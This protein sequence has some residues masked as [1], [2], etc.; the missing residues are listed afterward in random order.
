MGI[1]R[2]RCTVT[3]VNCGTSVEAK[4][5]KKKYCSILCKDIYTA[6]ARSDY[7]KEYSAANTDKKRQQAA[8]WRERNSANLANINKASHERHRDKK[9]WA[10]Y[11]ARYGITQQEYEAK[12]VEQGRLC[13]ICRKPETA[14]QGGRIRMLSVDHDH[15]S[16]K[17]RDLL[18]SKCNAGLGMFADDPELLLDAYEYLVRHA[19]NP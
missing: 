3:C 16:G 17:I 7:F 11:A 4:S 19:A 18:C 12:L 10:V 8:A 14:A 1:R 5:E 15:E 9:A 2:W 13:R 6:Q